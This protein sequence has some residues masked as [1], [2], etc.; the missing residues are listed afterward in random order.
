[1]KRIIFRALFVFATAFTATYSSAQVNANFNTNPS[2]WEV[3]M[4]KGFMQGR[5]WQF[6]NMDANSCGWNP[7]IEGDAGMVSTNFEQTSGLYSPM[8][9]VPGSMAVGFKYEFNQEVSGNASIQLFLVTHNNEIVQELATIDATSATI[10]TIYYY[11]NTFTN[12]PSGAYKLNIVF[13]C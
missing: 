13:S 4:I 2:A 11:N 1:M 6:V 8:L 12:L 3:N 5:C 9:D 10:N 7:G